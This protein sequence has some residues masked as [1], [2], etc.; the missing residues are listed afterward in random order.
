MVLRDALA[1][2]SWS[3]ALLW[4]DA[5]IVCRLPATAQVLSAIAAARQAGISSWYD[6]DD[7]VVD[8]DHGIPPLASYG[9]TIT[10]LQ[11]RLLQL[12]VPLFATAMRACDGAIVSTGP[13]ADR[14]R[15]LNPGQPV[16]QLANLI[17]PGSA[18]RPALAAATPLPSPGGGQRHQC[19]QTDLDQGSPLANAS[20]ASPLQLDLLCELQLPLVLLPF[21][22]RIR[23]HPSATTPPMCS[24]GGGG[25]RPGALEPAHRCQERHPL[26]G[27]Q[28]LWSGQCA[29]PHGHLHRAAGGRRPCPLRAGPEQWLEAVEQLLADPAGR[30]AMAGGLSSTQQLF[31]LHQAE[32]F[33]RPLIE[34]VEPSRLN[35]AKNCCAQCLLCAPVHRRCHPGGTGPGAG[36]GR[37]V[38]R[39]VGDHGAL[40]AG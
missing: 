11:H 8:A 16:L 4:A 36:P 14:W 22:E 38:R 37:A 7:L 40:H 13:L 30:R 5:L 20:G 32:A 1:D 10:P 3:E 33:W 15:Q 12:D 39:S 18:S 19:P 21:A 24:A 23:R 35:T 17:P 2:Q 28:P 31:G 34:P 29:Q 9:G 27:V 6:L 25:H 26:D